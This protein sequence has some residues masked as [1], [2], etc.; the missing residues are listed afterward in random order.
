MVVG[1]ASESHRAVHP[2]A[3]FLERRTGLV[4]DP[5]VGGV[6]FR[7]RRSGVLFEDDVLEFEGEG[8]EIA[9]ESKGQFELSP[10]GLQFGK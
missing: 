9:S 6:V 4:Q 1:L 3:T 7:D 10:L 8:F 2:N 5:D